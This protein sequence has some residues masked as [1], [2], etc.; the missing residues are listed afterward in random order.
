MKYEHIKCRMP[1]CTNHQDEGSFVGE[2]CSPCHH[3]LNQIV[4]ERI[5]DVIQRIMQLEKRVSRMGMSRLD[6]IAELEKHEDKALMYQ[7]K[8]K[9]FADQARDLNE[10]LLKCQSDNE[11]R[12]ESDDD[13]GKCDRVNGDGCA[14]PGCDCGGD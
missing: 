8:T 10:E 9:Y 3:M 5:G 6:L 11:S 13:T 12:K 4:E 2:F 7:C 14:C 1:G